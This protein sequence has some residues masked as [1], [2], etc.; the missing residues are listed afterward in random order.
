L[1]RNFLLQAA[2]ASFIIT[3]I[4]AA[5]TPQ[6]E[7]EQPESWEKESF[8]PG[9]GQYQDIQLAADDEIHR[10]TLRIDIKEAHPHQK[11]SNKVYIALMDREDESRILFWVSRSVK[12]IGK[13]VVRIYRDDDSEKPHY[14]E[15]QGLKDYVGEHELTIQIDNEGNMSFLVNGVVLETHPKHF[16]I[17]G[18]QIRVIGTTTDVSWAIE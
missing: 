12:K 7:R 13:A 5:P 15:S 11:W 2:S 18:I 17:D 1:L 8:D 6:N 14:L 10:I 16:R 9:A 3:S 4:A